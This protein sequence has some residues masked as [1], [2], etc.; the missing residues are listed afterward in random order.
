MRSL[1]NE[2]RVRWRMQILMIVGAT[3]M[4]VT[5]IHAQS[6]RPAPSDPPPT[7]PTKGDSSD[8]NF[9]S[10]ENEMRDKLRVKE[11]KKRYDENVGRA[12]EA[13]E[14]GSQLLKS[15]EARKVF[16]SDDS[17]KL[18]RLEKLTRRI[19]NEAGGSESDPDVKDIPGDF[20]LA[21]KRLAEMSD[22]LFKLVEKTP[23]L[24]VSAAV[25]DQ[26][27]KVIGLIQ[28][29]RNPSR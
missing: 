24:V 2:I 6:P 25:I 4:L 17:K 12:R 28:H 7:N 20:E 18:E 1:P 13:S 3:L 15:F 26:A 27:N 5:A 29:V 16:N 23:R 11:D 8:T 10:P 21:V 9:G 22:E 14:L 19:R